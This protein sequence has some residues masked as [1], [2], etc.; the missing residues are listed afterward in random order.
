MTTGINHKEEGY[1]VLEQHPHSIFAADLNGNIT[2]WNSASENLLGYSRKEMLNHSFKK[3]YADQDSAQFSRILKQLSEGRNIKSHWYGRKRDGTSFWFQLNARVVNNQQGIPTSI[4]ASLTDC[5]TLQETQSELVDFKKQIHAL[6]ETTVD[7]VAIIDEN[8]CIQSFNKAA[9]KI[10]DYEEEEVLGKNYRIL[11]PEHHKD[12]TGDYLKKIFNIEGNDFIGIRRELTG[13]RKDGS[14]FPMELSVTKSS[15]NNKKVFMGVAND[16]SERRRLEQEILWIA[17]EERRNIGQDMHDGL[18]QT[19]TGVALISKTLARKLEQ[20][21]I[22]E[23]YE[24]QQIAEMVQEANDQARALAHGLV[25]LGVEEDGLNTSLKR[26]GERVNTLFGIECSIE[27]DAG[28]IIDNDVT[29]LNLYRIVQEAINNAHKHG[30]ADAVQVS[31]KQDGD[32]INLFV[33]NNGIPFSLSEVDDDRTGMGL[34]IMRYRSNMIS[35]L[36]DIIVN[37]KGNT[38]TYC[39]FPRDYCKI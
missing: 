25:H 11:I 39:R 24:V 1:E 37:K 27:I 28:V 38:R 34:H 21:G 6:L 18:G 26:L 33:D 20:K 31:L 30:K 17:E 9:T 29:A 10:F 15:L 35:G 16:I 14:I 3:I 13:Q 7:G 2:F 12:G 32:F 5:N 4:L 23:S 36:F 19:L 22:P 8:G